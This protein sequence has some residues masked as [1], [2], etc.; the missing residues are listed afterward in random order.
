MRATAE[1]V[2]TLRRTHGSYDYLGAKHLKKFIRVRNPLSSV[3]VNL[4]LSHQE[5]L[6]HQDAFHHLLDG[7]AHS[8]E[9]PALIPEAGFF[10]QFLME[11]LCGVQ[12]F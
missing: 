11:Q 12:I 5:L 4:E 1:C 10:S 9:K 7:E 3:Q 2:Y 6:V 8:F